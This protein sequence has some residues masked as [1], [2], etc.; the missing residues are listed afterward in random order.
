MKAYLDIDIG[1]NSKY[2]EDLDS[3]NRTVKFYLEIY[4][5]YG[6]E[7]HDSIENCTEEEKEIIQGEHAAR[8]HSGSL[9]FR[10]P[11]DLRAGRIII[12]FFD[13]CPK[14]VAN[15]KV[16]LLKQ[17]SYLPNRCI[18]LVYWGKR[19]IKI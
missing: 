8:K 11:K 10:K 1:D 18:G 13:D 14:T 4:Q 6:W 16:R 15:F 5:N 17:F 19:K 12:E 2:N 7:K 9:S 3:Y